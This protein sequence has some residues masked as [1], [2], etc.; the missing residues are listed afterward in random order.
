MVG[1]YPIGTEDVITCPYNMALATSQ[2]RQYASCVFPIEN[3]ALLDIVA[4]HDKQVSVS[5]KPYQDMNRVIAN[6]MLHLT[7]YEL[8]WEGGWE[9]NDFLGFSG[10]RFKGEINVDLN[11][12]ST[13]MVPYPNVNFLSSSYSPTFP[14]RHVTLSAIIVTVI[15]N[16]IA[17]FFHFVTYKLLWRQHE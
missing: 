13:N 9:R 4:R 3:R 6:M 7:W 10:S 2:L 11:E 1:V 14:T 12:I 16:F 8:F 17:S 15:F 5:F